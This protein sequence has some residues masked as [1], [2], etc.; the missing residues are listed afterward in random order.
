MLYFKL[1]NIYLQ[2]TWLH[3]FIVI[4]LNFKFCMYGNNDKISYLLSNIAYIAADK[5]RTVYKA[6]FN[7]FYYRCNNIHITVLR[8]I[9]M[10]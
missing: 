2:L 8:V 4:N 6:V 3:R 1:E 5:T 7:P 10:I 9:P